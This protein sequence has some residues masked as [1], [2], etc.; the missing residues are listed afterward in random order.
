MIHWANARQNKKVFKACLK[1]NS[2]D[3]PNV[4]VATGRVLYHEGW[5]SMIEGP[6]L[7]SLAL[8]LYRFPQRS[9]FQKTDTI[10][11]CIVDAHV[12]GMF[13]TKQYYCSHYEIFAEMGD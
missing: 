11:S 5:A 13:P 9:T 10:L 1:L 4:K 12:K 2:A 7:E 6:V 8:T 3:A